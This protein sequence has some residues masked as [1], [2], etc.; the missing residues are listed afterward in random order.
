MNQNNPSSHN[1]QTTASSS[2]STSSVYAKKAKRDYKI[3]TQN[4][5]QKEIDELANECSAVLGL[6]CAECKTLLSKY[7]WDKHVL[8][9]RY[10]ETDDTEKLLKQAGILDPERHAPPIKG[11]KGLCQICFDKGQLQG[12]LC[13]HLFCSN[14]WCQ[15]LEQK[16]LIEHCPHV[17]C[18]AENCQIVVDEDF[19]IPK[20]RAKG[21]QNALNKFRWVQVNTFVQGNPLIKWCPGI[22]CGRAVKVQLSEARRIRCECGHEYCFQCLQPWHA[23]VGCAL[24]KIWLKQ[25]SDDS[26]TYNWINAFTKDCPKCKTAIEKNGGCNHMT[27]RNKACGYQFCWV[28]MGDWKSHNGNYSCNRYTDEVKNKE[29]QADESRSA[30][31]RYLHYYDRFRN[32]ENS[33]KFEHKLYEQVH[34]KIKHFQAANFSYVETLF[35][36]TAV[37]VLCE[38]RRTLMYTYAFAYYLTQDHM[39]TNIFENNQQ[40]LEVA[41]EQLSEFLERDLA[42]EQDLSD[43]KRKV[44]DKSRYVESRRM[45]MLQ[46]CVEGTERGQ[47]HYNRSE[48]KSQQD[49]T[50]INIS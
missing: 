43:L 17:L 28:C 11:K 29:K 48:L 40:D 3:L 47:W 39:Q 15:Y 35:M 50:V 9:E 34:A 22:N 4:E 23:P 2:N 26:E 18:P 49:G 12:L 36:E 27:C 46:H 5:L 19:S 33:L 45:I 21:G 44:Q 32:H 1:L 25:C 10:F 16:I 13:A 14:C 41:T 24:L 30:L 6:S 20:L 31:K 7:K 8:L 38:C 37:D 42:N